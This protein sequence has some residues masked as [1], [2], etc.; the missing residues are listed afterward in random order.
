MLER[1]HGRDGGRAPVWRGR[2]SAVRRRGAPA[3]T[4]ILLADPDAALRSALGDTLRRVG[5]AV[6]PAA[7]GAAAVAVARQTPPDLILL[8]VLL[9]RVDGLEVCRRLRASDDR[10][11]RTV[12]VLMCSARGDEV[13]RVVG[14]EVGADDYVPKPVPLRELL[15]RVRALLRRARWAA[16]GAAEGAAARLTVGDLELDPATRTVRRRG[17]EVPLTPR[18]FDLL[19]FLLRHPGRVFTRTQLLE[20]VWGAG[21]GAYVGDVR[22]VD[23]HVRWLRAKLEADPGAPAVLETVRGVGYRAGLALPRAASDAVT[24]EPWPGPHRGRGRPFPK[25]PSTGRRP[26]AGS[27]SE[28][29]L[30]A[31]GRRSA[32]TGWRRAGTPLRTASVSRAPDATVQAEGSPDGRSRVH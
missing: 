31:S 25:P 20:H 23:V 1:D 3:M 14:L 28:V 4:T 30:P 10:R 21:D 12:P 16:E 9:P 18:E 7:D 32:R 27:P 17:A 26:Q 8:A 29:A 13:D 5:Y 15:A 24:R 19:A 22:T 11:L 6:R 2:V